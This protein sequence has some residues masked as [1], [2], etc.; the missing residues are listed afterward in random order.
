MLQLLPIHTSIIRAR[1][2]SPVG[3]IVLFER[4]GILHGDTLAHYL[5]SQDLT[6]FAIQAKGPDGK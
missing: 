5:C 4:P 2:L 3:E 1:V 6:R